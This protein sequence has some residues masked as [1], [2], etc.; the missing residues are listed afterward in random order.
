MDSAEEALKGGIMA[1]VLVTAIQNWIGLSTDTKPTN[2]SVGSTF[3]ESNTGKQWVYNETQWVEDLRI[4]YAAYE[5]S[6]A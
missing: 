1:V 6:R 4:I 3:H 5:A 2:P